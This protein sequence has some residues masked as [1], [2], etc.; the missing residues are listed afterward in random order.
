MPPPP[1]H[2]AHLHNLREQ[3]KMKSIA[4][5]LAH[6]AL[7]AH[8]YAYLS[9]YVPRRATEARIGQFSR[10]LAHVGTFSDHRAQKF[11][12]SATV[13]GDIVP[14]LEQLIR[15]TTDEDALRLVWHVQDAVELDFITQGWTY[16]AAE[17]FAYRTPPSLAARGRQRFV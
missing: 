6:V 17:C 16:N 9:S 13:C 2:H 10:C 5:R 15:G 4:E 14:L 3:W 7:P 12:I 11:T 1:A 8:L